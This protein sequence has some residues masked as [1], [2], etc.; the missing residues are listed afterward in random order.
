MNLKDILAVSGQSGLFRYI[1]QGKNGF[2]LEHLTEKK[3]IHAPATAKISGLEDI[4]IFTDD[5]EIPLKGVFQIIFKKESGNPALS[6]KSS[7]QDLKGYFA[8]VLPAYDRNKVYVSDIRKVLLWYNSLQE[9]G[10]I[11]LENEPLKEETP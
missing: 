11:D 2:I 3:R 4:A 6:H 9:L 7:D 8:S 1:S 5:E 10:M